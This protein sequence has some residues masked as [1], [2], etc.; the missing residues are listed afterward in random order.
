MV[1]RL[2]GSIDCG[3]AALALVL[4]LAQPCALE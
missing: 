4:A 1:T 2:C 3:F